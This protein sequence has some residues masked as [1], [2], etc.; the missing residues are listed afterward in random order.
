M[1]GDGDLRELAHLE[2][3]SARRGN[4]RRQIS[5][6][7]ATSKRELQRIEFDAGTGSIAFRRFVSE[8]RA[9]VGLDSLER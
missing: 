9:A 6:H 8:S 1:F 2:P 7:N 4:T 5:A 3:L